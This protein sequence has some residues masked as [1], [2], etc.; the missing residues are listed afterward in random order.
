MPLVPPTAGAI[1]PTAGPV[2][3]PLPVAPLDDPLGLPA[4][5]IISADGIILE[6]IY[7][8]VDEAGIDA[9]LG[10]WFGG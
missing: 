7:G 8:Q 10:Q 3:E 1:P 9:K 5:Y 6:R 2:L 4:S